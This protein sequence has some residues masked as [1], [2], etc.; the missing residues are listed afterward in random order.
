MSHEIEMQGCLTIPD[1]VDYDKVTDMFLEFIE[2]HGW[3]YGGGFTEIRDGHYV[4]PDGTLGT[5]V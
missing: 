4:K 2:S 5:A 1:D 3:I